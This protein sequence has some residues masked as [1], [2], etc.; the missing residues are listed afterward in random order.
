MRTSENSVQA[1]YVNQP[2]AEA[3]LPRLIGGDRVVP[4]QSDPPCV[5]L[6]QEGVGAPQGH[7]IAAAEVG[8][9]ILATPEL[10][11]PADPARLSLCSHQPLDAPPLL[12]AEVS[13]H[14]ARLSLVLPRLPP[15]HSTPPWAL[16]GLLCPSRS[17][18]GPCTILPHKRRSSSLT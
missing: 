4:D 15:Q 10:R 2:L 14:D 11:V 8:G 7:A 6:S 5:V 12:L 17:G 3:D 18:P 9:G 16:Y 1:K 13:P